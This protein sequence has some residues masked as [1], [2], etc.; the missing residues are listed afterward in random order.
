MLAVVRSFLLLED[1][2]EIDWEVADEPIEPSWRGS[3]SST[4]IEVDHA[5]HPH[6]EALR[7]RLGDRRPGA[8]RPREQVC[9]CPLPPSVQRRGREEQ[10]EGDPQRGSRITTGMTRVVIDR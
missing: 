7:S 1:D 10:R 3:R 6:R 5:G 2:C 4:G 9:L 8:G